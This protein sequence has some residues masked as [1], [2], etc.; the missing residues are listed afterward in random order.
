MQ[1]NGT[2]VSH[3]SAKFGGFQFTHELEGCFERLTNLLDRFLSSEA[4]HFPHPVGLVAENVRQNA[5]A[6]LA[7][8]PEACLT[9]AFLVTRVMLDSALTASYLL[10]ADSNERE[11][12]LAQA[13]SV[14][15]LRQGTPDEIIAQAKTLKQPD[16]IPLHRLKPLNDRLEIICS[17][18]GANRDA[19]RMLVAS[20]Y[21][22]T[23]E[24]LAGSIHGYAFRFGPM[25]ERNSGG[26]FSM[27]FLMGSSILHE[28]I[29]ALAKHI[30]SDFWKVESTAV[31]D[32]VCALMQ[33]SK[34]GIDSPV[35]GAWDRMERL[36][37][38]GSRKLSP[39]LAEFQEAFTLS[40]EAAL[41]APTLRKQD[42]RERFKHAALYFRRALNDLRAVWILLANGYTAQASSCAGSLFESCLATICLLEDDNIQRYESKRLSVTG[43]DFPWGAME[44]AK[45]VCAKGCDLTVPNPKYENSWRS[46]YARYVWLSQIRHSTFQSVIHEAASTKL[47]CGDYL[48]MAMPNCTESDLPVKIGIAIGALVDIQDATDALLSAFEYNP[49]AGNQLFDD[50]KQNAAAKIDSLV[51]VYMQM[52]NPITIAGTK[53]M[54]RHPPVPEN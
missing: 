18:T 31:N 45:M 26:G 9:E 22:E 50:R 47:D 19:W 40:Y 43:N 35:Q 34:A 7:L 52:K 53:F 37:Y 11:A 10:V 14:E 28:L 16:H 21:P 15:A 44:M 42:D 5:L 4:K 23:T 36:E 8:T 30:N 1:T 46:L 27:V 25:S 51:R 38:L 17:K 33:K 41:I 48:I 6:I 54:L 39:Q 13:P 3:E 32:K 2:S 49:Q 29:T 12:Y 24:M 20:I